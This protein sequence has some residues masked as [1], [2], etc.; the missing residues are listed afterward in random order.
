[1]NVPK[2]DIEYFEGITAPYID[3]VGGGNFDGYLV[4][5]SLIFKQLNKKVEL[6][7]KVVDK[8]RYDGKIE[9]SVLIGTFEQSDKDTITLIFEH[10][11]MRGKILGKNEEMIVFD[12]W[13]TATKRTEVYKIKE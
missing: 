9:D 5:K 12:I 8:T 1:M 10:F 13:H 2:Y 7:T 6:H 11:Q 3:W 4:L